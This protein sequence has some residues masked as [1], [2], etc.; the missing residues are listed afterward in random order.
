LHWRFISVTLVLGTM[1]TETF[2]GGL[3]LGLYVGPGGVVFQV[4]VDDDGARLAFVPQA[5]AD[6]LRD[7]PAAHAETREDRPSHL[8]VCEM[9]RAVAEHDDVRLE[10]V[11]RKRAHLRVVRETVV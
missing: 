9:P 10:R 5:G 1:T 3:A 4:V 7:V 11:R 2:S 6:K 8:A